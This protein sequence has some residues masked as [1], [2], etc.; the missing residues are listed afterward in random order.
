MKIQ[1]DI[2]KYRI[3]TVKSQK[4]PKEQIALYCA[5]MLFPLDEKRKKNVTTKG[6][7]GVS[8]KS[9]KRIR[10]VNRLACLTTQNICGISMRARARIRNQEKNVRFLSTHPIEDGR[11]VSVS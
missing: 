8:K 2:V 11:C 10:V 5:C 3:Q 4:N 9:G 1:A 7:F 6:N